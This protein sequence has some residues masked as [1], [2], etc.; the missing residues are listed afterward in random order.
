MFHVERPIILIDT[1]F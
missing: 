1:P